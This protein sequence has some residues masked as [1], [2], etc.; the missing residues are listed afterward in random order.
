MLRLVDEGV[1]VV[2]ADVPDVA[3]DAAVAA[4]ASRGGAG[5]FVR[6]DVRVDGDLEHMVAFASER[7]GGVDI[8]VNNAGG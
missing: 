3:G 2:V 1:A 8:L 5:S 7:H 4:I 6:T